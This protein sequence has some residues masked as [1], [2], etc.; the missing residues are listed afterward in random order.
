MSVD[1]ASWGSVFIGVSP[2]ES[3][4]WNGYGLLNYRHL[5]GRVERIGGRRE[6]VRVWEV[7]R[8]R[9]GVSKSWMGKR[10]LR[11]TDEE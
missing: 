3:S 1:A 9:K 11:R 4:S 8:G 10:K 5:V 2:G 7:V 6:R